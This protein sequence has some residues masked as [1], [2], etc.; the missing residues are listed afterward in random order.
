MTAKY[1]R[2]LRLVTGV[3]GFAGLAAVAFH[4]RELFLSFA[5]WK[6]IMCIL[7]LPGAAAFLF[8]AFHHEHTRSIP[9]VGGLD[10]ASVPCPAPTKPPSLSAGAAAAIPEHV[11]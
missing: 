9:G 5:F 7:A 1:K 2:F 4:T 10:S 6:L 3:L 11:D 8:F